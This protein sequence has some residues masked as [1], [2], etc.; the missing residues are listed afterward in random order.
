MFEG[1]FENS[2]EDDFLGL[3]TLGLSF[4]LGALLCVRRR[5]G[6]LTL[7]WLLAAMA[8]YA[9]VAGVSIALT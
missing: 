6:W 1:V 2:R 3:A 4:A 7:V 9:V 5:T 8:G